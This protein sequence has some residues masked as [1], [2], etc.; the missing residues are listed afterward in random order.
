MRDV[1]SVPFMVWYAI[2]AQNM[3]LLGFLNIDNLIKQLLM[4]TVYIN[5]AC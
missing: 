2:Q 5:K 1:V 4:D 3:F